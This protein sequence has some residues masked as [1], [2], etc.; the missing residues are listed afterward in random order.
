MAIAIAVAAYGALGL[1]PARE[2]YS[3]IEWSVVV[4]LACLLP[5]GVA[6]EQVGGTALIANSI[7]ELTWATRPCSRLSRS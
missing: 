4:M 1:V 7:A 3:Q 5:L 2:F 6:F